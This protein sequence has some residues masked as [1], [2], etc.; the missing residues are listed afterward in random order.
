MEPQL[1]KLV[2]SLAALTEWVNALYQQHLDE[3]SRKR[4][5]ELVK[6][7]RES[8]DAAV[9]QV[10][11]IAASVASGELREKS[12]KYI[13]DATQT[14]REAASSIQSKALSYKLPTAK[15]L[16]ETVD[17]NLKV[18]KARLATVSV[19]VAAVQASALEWS[20]SKLNG[21]AA[22]ADLRVA[23]DP[24]VQRISNT[25]ANVNEWLRAMYAKH[26]DEDSRAKIQSVA[27]DFY[28]YAVSV[29]SQLQ[30]TASKVK[31]DSSL[32][33]TAQVYF[34]ETS[35]KV[36]EVASSLQERAKQ[37]ANA[38]EL[39]SR[40]DESLKA[41][42]GRV[43][44]LSRDLVSM[45]AS[46]VEWG[47]KGTLSDLKTVVDPQVQRLQENIQHL[48][49]RLSQL[50]EEHVDQESRTRLNA[51]VEEFKVAVEAT[52]RHLQGSTSDLLGSKY[53]EDTSSLIQSAATQVCD[54][55]FSSLHGGFEENFQIIKEKVV[56]LS[57]EV[58]KVQAS[59]R[60]WSANK[61]HPTLQD[62]SSVVDPQVQRI[63]TLIRGISAWIQQMYEKHVDAD[64]RRKLQSLAEQLKET[65]DTAQTALVAAAGEVR[66]V[67]GRY[68]NETTESVA[69]A[70]NVYFEPT[71]KRI[72]PRVEEAISHVNPYVEKVQDVV[73]KECP[74]ATK[75]VAEIK[76]IAGAEKP[77]MERAFLIA[78]LILQTLFVLLTTSATA[79][80]EQLYKKA[81]TTGPVA[82]ESSSP[83]SS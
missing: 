1:Q 12:L 60:Q 66:G 59:V 51:S 28:A 83:V 41:V 37:Y 2:E 73:S 76:T 45:Q 26:V 24:H 55:R 72:A 48:Y 7:A 6:Q 70:A 32:S 18:V 58:T 79:A 30:D 80:R 50:Y 19:D 71:Y 15:D 64:S 63:G 25:L 42:S 75:N 44:E 21:E 68:I 77:L 10:Q 39:Q 40:L 27:S 22:L 81:D 4:L 47:S 61:N 5:E 54:L 23:V 20:T 49:E 8:V 78:M 38:K 36:L 52:L 16:H 74:E 13:T 65:V 67:A 31:V 46:A 56:D 69:R 3:A 29:A 14:V 11:G 82:Q 17:E 62:L 34:T 35:T 9:Q 53:I 33:G 43:S 57:G